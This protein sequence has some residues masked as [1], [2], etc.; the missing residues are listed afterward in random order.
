[1]NVVEAGTYRIL[2]EPGKLVEVNMAWHELELALERY[3]SG[4]WISA[5][6]G[7]VMVATV[8]A[9]LAMTS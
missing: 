8:L 3:E 9:L 7:I 2:V 6:V 4:R 1:M 5:A